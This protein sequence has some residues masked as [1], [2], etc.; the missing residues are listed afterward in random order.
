[1]ADIEVNGP[2]VSIIVSLNQDSRFQHIGDLLEFFYPQEGNVDF[3]FI[4]VDVPN[5]GRAR[6]YRER[7]P[8][9]TLIQPERLLPALR[10]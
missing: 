2:K 9:I 6:I 7:F 8:W 1:M 4:V 10:I 3:E 5:E